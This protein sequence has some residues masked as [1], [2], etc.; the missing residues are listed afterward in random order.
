MRT[1]NQHS[2]TTSRFAP[3]L[4]ALLGAFGAACTN[5]EEP[6]P[7]LL[8]IDRDFFDFGQLMVGQTS[9]ERVFTIRNAGPDA[10]DGLDVR[11]ESND[12][13]LLVGTTCVGWLEASETCTA[14]VAFA[15]GQAGAVQGDL[16]VDAYHAEARVHLAGTGAALVRMTN[17]AASNP[18]VVSEPAGIRCGSVCEAIFTVPEV[19][20]TVPDGGFATWSGPCETTAGGSCLLRLQGETSVVLL[21]FASAVQWIF[22]GSGLVNGLMIDSQNNVIG[23]GGGSPLLF[24]LSPAGEVLWQT[25][26]FGAG[27]A[28]AI[29]S[30]GNIAL[31]S[32]TSVWK[33]DGAGEAQ[34]G[35]VFLSQVTE[36]RNVA[37]DPAGN[38]YVAGVQRSGTESSVHLV[39]YDRD[40]TWLWS[41]YYASATMNEVMGLAVD[42]DGDVIISGFA[43]ADP[44]EGLTMQFLRKYDDDGNVLWTNEST[45]IFGY[46]L[47]VDG[48]GNI[49]VA[50]RVGGG[51]PGSYSLHK[52]TAEGGLLWETHADDI[53]GLVSGLAVTDAGDVI[54]IGTRYNEDNKAVG[55]W[56]AKFD[57]IDGTRRRPIE[58]QLQG[59]RQF[60]RD[61][62]VDGNG[63]VLLAGG[64][65][66]PW[67]RK[68]DGAAFDQPA[69]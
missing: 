7:G 11:L 35:P 58:I 63:D 22:N 28:A 9:A 45:G 49:F 4:L 37:F 32:F 48:S 25:D 41:Q 26:D 64:E 6:E 27:L 43:S 36:I 18:L 19:V 62:A 57:G 8:V 55:V 2:H 67:L 13:F 50:D 56:A 47:A 46:E 52:Y 17:T 10:L 34:W 59:E 61:V 44:A 21:D 54:A 39:K 53:G 33:I 66:D 1:M 14:T 42:G 68:Y 31:A 40:G 38:L 20:L 12:T 15:P 65:D 60:S 69:E 29:D 5:E 51:S 30:Q 24:K 3:C 23:A 16:V